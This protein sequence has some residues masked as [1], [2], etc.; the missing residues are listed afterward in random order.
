MLFS[1]GRIFQKTDTIKK[2]FSACLI[3]PSTEI[4]VVDFDINHEFTQIQRIGKSLKYC[5]RIPVFHYL[6]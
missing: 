2:Y 6:K 5:A 1:V 3:I 4:G